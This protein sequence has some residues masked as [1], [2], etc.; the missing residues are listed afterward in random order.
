V[1]DI[2]N[3]LQ[4]PSIALTPNWT[5]LEVEYFAHPCESMSKLNALLMS[6]KELF[7]Y[8]W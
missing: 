8:V 3:R 5:S 1:K 2:Q 4:V 6:L 7:A